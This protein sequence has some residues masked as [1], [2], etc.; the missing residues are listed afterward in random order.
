MCMHEV[1]K[2]RNASQLLKRLIGSNDVFP[3]SYDLL[4]IRDD[5]RLRSIRN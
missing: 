1:Y 3:R 4:D 5:Q 2:S